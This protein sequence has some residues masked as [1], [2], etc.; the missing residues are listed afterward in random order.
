MPIYEETYASWQ[1]KRLTHPATWLVIA[2]SG[3]RMLWT[4]GMILFLFFASIPFMVRA[5]QI[6][7]FS[8]LGSQVIVQ[9]QSLQALKINPHF[10]LSFLQGQFFYLLIILVF[11]GT[12]LIANDKKYKAFSL[13]FS[14]PV[15]LIDYLSGK[16]LIISSYGLAI[17]LVPGLLL[18]LIQLALSRDAAFAQTYYW[19]PFSLIAASLL[20]VS[21]LAVVALAF[22][23]LGN[24][25][26]TAA[27]LF[28]GTLVFP[29]LIRAIFPSVKIL[30]LLSLQADI[31]QVITPLF[32]ESSPY[33]A[34]VWLSIL[35]LLLVVALCLFLFKR[36][37]KPVE[38]VR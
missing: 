31:N 19:I 23:S 30:V 27:I 11:V 25:Q 17:T 8:R 22:S 2:R 33:P 38:V 7:V 36:K 1:G 32:G 3:I 21:I 5:I 26:R 29:D 28:F 15:S 20:A 9:S 35:M 10:F 16:Y 14:K 18:F 13:Y 6:Y 24:N 37:V 34:P 4:R 12:G